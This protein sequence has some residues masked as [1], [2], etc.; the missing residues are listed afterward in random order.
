MNK[1]DYLAK[2]DISR[3]WESRPN[4]IGPYYTILK[5]LVENLTGKSLLDVGCATGIDTEAFSEKG[6][7]AEG[8]DIK[9]DFIA[10]ASQKFPDLKFKVGSAESLPYDNESFDIVF[11]INTLFYTDIEKSLRELL[12]VTKTNG[13]CIFSFDTEIINL[14]E[15]KIF[16]SENLE[17]LRK[18]VEN[19]RS[20]IVYLGDEQKRADSEPFRHRHTFM[21]VV[22]QKK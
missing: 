8:V 3:H 1:D 7:V 14:D 12:R 15:D 19:N 4:Q 2:A 20:E 10:E 13:H 18:V 17:H 21:I 5:K 22:V 9:E 6:L 16:H 11:C